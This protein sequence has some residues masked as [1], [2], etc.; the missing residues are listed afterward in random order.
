MIRAATAATDKPAIWAGVILALS[1]SSATGSATGVEVDDVDDVDDVE[2]VA[3]AGRDME[4]T[5]TD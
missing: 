3:E 1:S 2:E 4:S 5:K